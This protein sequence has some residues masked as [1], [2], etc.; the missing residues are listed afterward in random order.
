MIRLTTIRLPKTK[1]LDHVYVAPGLSLGI[2]GPADSGKTALLLALM[3]QAVAGTSFDRQSDLEIVDIGY[4]PSNPSFLFSGMKSDL[5]GE[6]HLSAQFVGRSPD[7]LDEIAHR[8]QIEGLLARDPFSLSG[9]EMVRAALAIVAAKKPKVWLLDQIYDWLYPDSMDELRRMV[10]SEL[11]LG[12]AV[13]ETHTSSPQWVDRFDSAI[14]LDDGGETVVGVYP[15]IA[16]RVR[17]WNLLS[18]VSR[19]SFRFEEDL[20]VRIDDHH[21]TDAIVDAIRPLIRES[22]QPGRQSSAKVEP[23]VKMDDLSFR[24]ATGDFALGPIKMTLCKSEIVAVAGPNGSGKSTFLQCI[25]DLLAPISGDLRILGDKPT[26]RRWE[27]ARKAFYCFQ[28]PD[29]QLYMPTTFE[30]IEKTLKALGR[31]L[32]SDIAARF[33]SFGLTP[34]LDREPYQ[35]AR[36]VRRMVCLAAGL[37]SSTPVILL[38]EPAASLDVKARA[39]I[40]AEIERLAGTGVTFLMVSHDFSFIAETATRILKFADGR[41]VGDTASAPWPLDHLPP[42]LRVASRLGLEGA[43]YSDIVGSIRPATAS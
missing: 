16:R 37:M 5:S 35:L 11:A 29:D 24:Y 31:P 23:M 20:G 9:G 7:G 43:R 17:N 25:A 40:Q 4:V 18:E 3:G 30:E 12:H 8:F 19:L 41:I 34:Y 26:K 1:Q 32:P 14:F 10:E 38:D 6:L 42:L 13:V 2:I 33:E 21:D 15:A 22:A 36:P 28:N 27:W 39:A